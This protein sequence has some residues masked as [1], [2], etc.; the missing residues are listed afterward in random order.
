MYIY[1]S[2]LIISWFPF[3]KRYG[4]PPCV[5][6]SPYGSSAL[7]GGRRLAGEMVRQA[8]RTKHY[9]PSLIPMVTISIVGSQR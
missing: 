7:Q 9:G 6:K 1:I 5:V 8:P 3:V 2:T 4:C